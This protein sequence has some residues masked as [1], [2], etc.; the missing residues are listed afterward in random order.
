MIIIYT[1]QNDNKLHIVVPAKLE[2]LQ[3]EVEGLNNENFM[4]FILH[5]DV[6]K[7]AINPCIVSRDIIPDDIYFRDAWKQ[8]ENT[9]IVDIEMAREV[10]MNNLIIIRD[11]K[12]KELDSVYIESLEKKDG[13]EDKVSAQR[14]ELRNMESTYSTVLANLSDLDQIKNFIPEILM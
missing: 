7:D 3:S 10:H 8:K 1:N 12:L 11:K 13:S 14:Q 4:Q 5:K 9:I 2:Q 6:P